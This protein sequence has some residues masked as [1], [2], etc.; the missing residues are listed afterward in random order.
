MIKLDVLGRCKIKCNYKH[1]D[2]E[3]EFYV[4]KTQSS[5]ILGLKSCLDLE[6]IKLIY[7]VDHSVTPESYD[8]AGLDKAAV[9]NDFEDVF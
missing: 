1:Q 3:I 5:P 2:S 7:S 8:N 9:L 4:V 6:L